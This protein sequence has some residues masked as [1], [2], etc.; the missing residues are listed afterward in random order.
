MRSSN[1]A[2]YIL[3]ALALM[4]PR[5]A[6]ATCGEECDGQYASE[7]DDCHSQYGDDPRDADDLT[8]CI[9]EARDDYRS[10]LNDCA[11]A[12]IS[13]P[14][15]WGLAG[16]TLTAPVRSPCRGPARNGAALPWAVRALWE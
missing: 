8:N 3:V 4:S 12:A 10:C 15:R 11:G 1:L 13:I 9:Q 2:G 7:I 6:N 16:S 14:R 5:A